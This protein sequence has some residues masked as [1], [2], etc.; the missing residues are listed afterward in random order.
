[1]QVYPV[2]YNLTA[3]APT[4]VM[5]IRNRGT[6]NSLFQL[7][8]SKWS[9]TGSGE[10]V[11]E[12]T[13]DILVN[14]GLFLL[15]GSD[16]Q[17]ARFGLRAAAEPVERSYRVIIQE[18]PQQQLTTNGLLT[19]LR[20]SVP[21]FVPPTAPIV[22][23]LVW[24]ARPAK[25]GIQLLASNQGNVHFQISKIRLLTATGAP[26]SEKVL[27][28]YVLPGAAQI[29]TVEAKAPPAVGAMIQL[30]AESDQGDLSET[31]RVDAA[32]DAPARP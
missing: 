20:V 5:T 15:R 16:V 12:A 4:G 24:A 18:V 3:Q 13:R 14:P 1:M 29:I 7:G 26:L 8:V 25:G 17:I 6:T 10:D 30:Q 21:V 32:P 27:N 19:L 22:K 28:A 2:R 9:Q 31:L 11:L 23:K